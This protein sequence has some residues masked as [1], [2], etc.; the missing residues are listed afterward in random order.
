MSVKQISV[1]LE[2]KAGRLAH[3]TQVLGE[4]NINI[5]ALSLADTE[6]FGIIRLIV[7]RPGEVYQ[8][9][10]DMAFTVSQTEV[11]AIEI[12][13]EP[14]GLNRILTVLGENGVNLEYLYA[15]LEPKSTGAMVVLRIEDIDAA[16]EVLANHNIK[17]LQAADLYDL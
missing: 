5:R 4:K 9:L 12:A 14:G 8:L 7:D 11:L 1:F 15:F 3:L 17:T 6:T 13:D 10:K 2:N 16:K